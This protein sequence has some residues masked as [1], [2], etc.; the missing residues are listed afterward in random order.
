MVW[1]LVFLPGLL[2]GLVQGLMGFGAAI[3]MMIFLPQ[4][5]P[6]AQSAAVAGVIMA[7]SVI[8]LVWRYH[9][10]IHFRQIIVPFIVYA[11]VAA[12][13]VHL[14]QVL[15]V[16]LLRRLLGALLVSLAGYF[17]LSKRAANQT[18]PWWLAGL[19]MII[20]GFFNG[21]FGIGGPLMALY[22]LSLADTTADY[23][24]NLQTF[25]LIDVVYISTVRVLNGILT[26]VL[27]PHIMIGM[28]GAVIGTAL[29]ARILPRLPMTTVRHLIYLFIGLSGGYYLIAPV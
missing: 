3:V 11:S 17:S 21:L 12:Y 4:L 8:T 26:P 14:G 10:H 1:L 27:L 22:F 25:F 23:L 15:D 7:A 19:F 13:S 24:G 16:Q 9:Q 29:A 5:F 6:I 28:V 2:A 20:S 18:Y